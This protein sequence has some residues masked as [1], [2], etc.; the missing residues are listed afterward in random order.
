[1]EIQI[2]V[3]KNNKVISISGFEEKIN[4]EKHFYPEVTE[5]NLKEYFANIYNLY[6]INNDFLIKKPDDILIKNILLIENK[7]SKIETL[8]EKL[9]N[10]DYK[11][12]KCYEAFMRQQP[13]PYNLEELS[14]QR[15]TWRAE[16][17]Q[18]EEE[19]KTL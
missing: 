2:I 12:I 9:I 1:M 7:K 18:L 13:L 15:D 11:I 4:S 16:I 14:A 8:K 17:N 19:L 6:Y 3:D 5:E 10:T